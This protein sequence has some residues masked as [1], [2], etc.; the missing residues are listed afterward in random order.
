MLVTVT[1]IDEALAAEAAG[2]DGLIAKGNESGGRVG[3]SS[4]FVLLQKLVERVATPIWVQGGIGP[5]TAAA[6]L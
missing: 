4:A 6:C 5:H 2:A 1:S 3:E